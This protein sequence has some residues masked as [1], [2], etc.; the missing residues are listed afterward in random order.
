MSQ[1]HDFDWWYDKFKGLAQEARGY[2]VN[3]I[4]IFAQDD[5]LSDTEVTRG[6]RYGIGPAYAIGLLDWYETQ[7]RKESDEEDD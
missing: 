6:F 1:E 3:S 5:P 7:V 2:G 4:V